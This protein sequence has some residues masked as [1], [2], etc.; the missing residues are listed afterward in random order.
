[1]VFCCPFPVPRSVPCSNRRVIRPEGLLPSRLEKKYSR[2]AAI[3]SRK[4]APTAQPLPGRARAR[5]AGAS[6]RP[7]SLSSSCRVSSNPSGTLLFPPAQPTA[8]RQ[9]RAL[10][11]ASQTRVR[12]TPKSQAGSWRS[13]WGGPPCTP[14][15]ERQAPDRARQGCSPAPSLCGGSTTQSHERF[16]QKEV[17]WERFGPG[18]QPADPLTIQLLRPWYCCCQ[19]S[20]KEPEVPRTA[21]WG[22]CDAFS[23]RHFR[24]YY[25]DRWHKWT[26][27]IPNSTPHKTARQLDCRKRF[28]P[29]VL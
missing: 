11:A 26:C 4:S 23:S 21:L 25:K 13:S 3:K 5:A 14:W 7:G 2:S 10:S 9:Q 6:P 22:E 1:L 28:K 29:E 18:L 27:S 8:G 17:K 24:K 20:K 16:A 19:V 15:M 12:E